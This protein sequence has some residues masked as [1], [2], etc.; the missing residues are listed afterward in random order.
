MSNLPIELMGWLGSMMLAI[1]ALPLAVEALKNKR[2][3]L[4]RAFFHLWFWGEVLVC[5]YIVY[6]GPSP[7]LINY[8]VNILCLL[9][10]GRYRENVQS[11]RSDDS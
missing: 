4:N 6:Q 10:V 9:I 5:I 1:C 8:A 2:I 11:S 7:L 3:A